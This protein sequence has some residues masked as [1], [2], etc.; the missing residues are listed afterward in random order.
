MNTNQNQIIINGIVLA[1]K[2]VMAKY[3][4]YIKKSFSYSKELLKSLFTDKNLVKY[5]HQKQ[6]FDVVFIRLIPFN[7]LNCIAIF[8]NFIGFSIILCKF[9]FCIIIRSVSCNIVH[10]SKTIFLKLKRRQQTLT[11][12][13]ALIYGILMLCVD[14]MSFGQNLSTHFTNGMNSFNINSHG[15]FY[16]FCRRM[17]IPFFINTI[18]V[19]MTKSKFHQ[20]LLNEKLTPNKLKE[21]TETINDSLNSSKRSVNVHLINANNADIT[22]MLPPINFISTSK[23]PVLTFAQGNLDLGAAWLLA[24]GRH[25]RRYA[26]KSAMLSLALPESVSKKYID[27]AEGKNQLISTIAESLSELTGTGK[28]KLSNLIRS[29]K[30]LSFQSAKDYGFFDEESVPVKKK[31]TPEAAPKKSVKKTAIVVKKVSKKRRG[32][33]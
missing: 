23:V 9:Q 27:D 4:F 25:G 32:N 13:S 8:L 18:I 12:K 10:F 3:L 33:G 19:K 17:E 30:E 22:K 26:N 21:V 24:A 14:G 7:E 6:D 1:I 29:G 31:V 15:Y 11:V 20:I 16:S 5:N 2:I 28:S